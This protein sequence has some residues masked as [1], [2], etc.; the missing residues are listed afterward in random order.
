M[1]AALLGCG[2]N[3][4]WISN[5]AE[6]E[7]QLEGAI[8]RS[9]IRRLISY[10]VIQAKP[11]RRNSRGRA[12]FVWAQKAKGRRRGPGSRRGGQN[13][14]DPRKARW[15]RMIR[16]QRARLAQLRKEK[17]LDTANYR[18]FYR[19]AKG[20]MFKNLAHLDQSLR[21]AG[22]VKGGK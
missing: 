9:D 3:R 22:A 21:L 7:E 16:P 19:R 17:R 8:T 6:D 2:E 20:G 18:I 14:R 5:E 15:I 12:R 1:A 10:N 11:I 13:A 4:V